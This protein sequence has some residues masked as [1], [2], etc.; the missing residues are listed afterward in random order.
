LLAMGGD[1]IDLSEEAG[2]HGDDARVE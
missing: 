1:E 2:G